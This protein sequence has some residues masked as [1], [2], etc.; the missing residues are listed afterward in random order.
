MGGAQIHA[1]PINI[2]FASPR[3]K[4]MC[5]KTTVIVVAGRQFVGI[6]LYSVPFPC[7]RVKGSNVGSTTADLQTEWITS[8][9]IL[10]HRGIQV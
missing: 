3:T 8:G 4:V 1:L 10:E 5:H 2:L 6:G 7:S 9:V